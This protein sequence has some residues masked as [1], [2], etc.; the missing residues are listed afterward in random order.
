MHAVRSA[1][2]C[3]GIAAA[4]LPLLVGCASAGGV[5]GT[6]PKVELRLDPAEWTLVR[7]SGYA[8]VGMAEYVPLGESLE[9]R[10]R[11]ISV[12][13]FAQARMP[14]PVA[15]AA[16]SA[17]RGLLMSR[18]PDAYWAVWS[19]PAGADTHE[20]GS[21]VRDGAVWA[22]INFSVRGETDAA[23]RE[24]WLRRLPEARVSHETR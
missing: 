1:A 4:L 10:T 12:Q 23:T 14:Y 24:A 3:A 8:T 19:S 21:I 6:A 13:A 16:M 5:A 17:C 11:F 20:V 2:R 18:C 22:R 7:R 15:A 9:R